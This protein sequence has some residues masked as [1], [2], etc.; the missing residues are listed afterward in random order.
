MAKESPQTS[1]VPLNEKRRKLR[2]LDDRDRI[3]QLIDWYTKH[4]PG[5]EQR[6]PVNLTPEFLKHFAAHIEGKQWSYRGWVLVEHEGH[7]VKVEKIRK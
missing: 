7:P 5:H 3:D 6:L 2:R 1:W 4:K